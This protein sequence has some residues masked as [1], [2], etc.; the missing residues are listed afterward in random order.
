MKHFCKKLIAVSAAVMTMASAGLTANAYYLGRSD[1]PH[2]ISAL[3]NDYTTYGGSGYVWNTLVAQ[4]GLPVFDRQ[5]LLHK[6]G[7]NAVTIQSGRYGRSTTMFATMDWSIADIDALTKTQMYVD[8]LRVQ[9]DQGDKFGLQLEY[10]PYSNEDLNQF[11]LRLMGWYHAK[12]SLSGFRLYNYQYN[13]S[14]GYYSGDLC[15]NGYYFAG[16]NVSCS[17]GIT[18]FEKPV[19]VK[20]STGDDFITKVHFS[21]Y[22]TLPESGSILF[23]GS[24]TRTCNILTNVKFRYTNDDPNNLYV[25]NM[26]KK[27]YSQTYSVNSVFSGL[28][29]GNTLHTE[30]SGW[31]KTN[32]QNKNFLA[33]KSSGTTLYICTGSNLSIPNPQW[34]NSGE[35][36]LKALLSCGYKDAFKHNTWVMGNIDGYSQIVFCSGATTTSRGS[37]YYTCTPAKFRQLLNQ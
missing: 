16:L 22:V 21:G 10:E 19:L 6:P 30:I 23:G 28:L 18:E 31:M 3:D 8:R 13:A 29:D 33:A 27:S 2:P 20:N 15:L 1:S 26:F 35:T 7:V 4:Q 25:T 14:T 5:Y 37:S 9:N 32:F 11:G 36:K 24:S 12:M 17:D 34:N